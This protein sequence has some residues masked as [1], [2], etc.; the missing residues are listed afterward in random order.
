MDELVKSV[1]G[2]NIPTILIIGGTLFLLLAVARSIAGKVEAD[3]G[4]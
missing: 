4:V 1:F 3:K 2:A